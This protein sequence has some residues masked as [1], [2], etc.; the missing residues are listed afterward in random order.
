MRSVVR[1]R[2]SLSSRT[3]DVYINEHLTK[4]QATIL[5]DARLLVKAKKLQGAWSSGGNVFIRLS[6]LPDSRQIR[7]DDVRDLPSD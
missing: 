2:K 5:R 6:N 1:A 4:A 3:P 7:V